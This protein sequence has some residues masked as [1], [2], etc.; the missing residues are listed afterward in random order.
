M[1]ATI[2]SAKSRKIYRLFTSRKVLLH[3]S[4]YIRLLWTAQMLLAPYIF[5]SMTWRQRSP[6]EKTP[7]QK[8]K[9]NKCV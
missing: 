2:V 4:I 8:D 7:L 9:L 6:K 1:F 5:F 3:G